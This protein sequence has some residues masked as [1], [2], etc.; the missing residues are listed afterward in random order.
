[1]PSADH[2][3]LLES[4]EGPDYL[5]VGNVCPPKGANI[6]STTKIS[7]DMLSKHAKDTIMEEEVVAPTMEN[8]CMEVEDQ[9]ILLWGPHITLECVSQSDSFIP[10]CERSKPKP[11]FE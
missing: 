4:V 6:G 10:F 3:F 5:Y 11:L 7:E 1:M 8:M 2:H 9:S